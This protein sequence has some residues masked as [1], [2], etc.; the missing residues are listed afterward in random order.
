MVIDLPLRQGLEI[1]TAGRSPG[2]MAGMGI[3]AEIWG[4]NDDVTQLLLAGV[5]VKT[6]HHPVVQAHAY[7]QGLIPSLG[8]VILAL[9]VNAGAF[10]RRTGIAAQPPGDAR[11]G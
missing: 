10:G 8:I 1:A 4:P 7:E 11:P 9:L 6:E 3:E 2:A 5:E